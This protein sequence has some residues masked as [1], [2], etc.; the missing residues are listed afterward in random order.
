MEDVLMRIAENLVERVSGPMHLR[1]YLQ[2]TMA[3]I[4]AVLAGLRDA[5]AG[6]PP[7]FW[8]LL[9]D[10]VNRAA[11]LKNGWKDVSMVFALAL[12]LDLGYQ[13]FVQGTVFPFEMLIVAILLALVP[14]LVVR[15]LV[16]RFASRR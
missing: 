13:F 7:Y 9:N 1:V 2:P 14:Y 10:P 6:N 15:G 4:F 5:R 8:S 12:V 16:T 3:T 11:R